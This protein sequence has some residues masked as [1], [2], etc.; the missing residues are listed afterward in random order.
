MDMI[1]SDLQ[2]EI[3]NVLAAICFGSFLF[4]FIV[5][6]LTL[7]NSQMDKLWSILPPV[8][9][10]VIAVMGGMTPR[11]IV[12]AM[13]ATVWG[14]RLT[15]NFGRKGAYSIK[16]WTGEEDYRWKYLRSTKY[17]KSRVVW[18]VFDFLFISIYQNVLVL[19]ITLPALAC[20]GS[21]GFGW[22][23]IIATILT[24]GFILL[25]TIADEQQWRFQTTKWNMI[26][27]GRKLED[28][29]MPYK[30]GF[31]TTGLWGICRHP[32]Y[33]GEQGIW[34]SFYIFSIGAGVGICNW[35][36]IG[37]ILLILLFFGSAWLGEMISSSKYPEYAQYRKEVNKFLPIKKF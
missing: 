3:F 33:L 21:N 17:F 19:L 37:A 14:V 4:C 13:L 29:P 36:A 5:G 20:V 2:F 27:A 32:N 8:Y 23:D 10:W 30:K 6:E 12:M 35:S 34:A 15:Y 11:L 18:A 31:N 7:N 9:A 28:L 1:F 16:F 22:V 25:E 24:A 26:K